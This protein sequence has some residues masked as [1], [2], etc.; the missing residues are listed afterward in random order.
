PHDRAREH[1]LA[2]AGFADD[3]E[4][5][6]PVERECHAVHGT[7][8]SPVRLEVRAGVADVEE[9]DVGRDGREAVGAVECLTLPAAEHHQIRASCTSKR[10]RM[11]SPRWFRDRTV[12]KIA[13][14]ASM[15]MCA[16]CDRL[17]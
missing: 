3:P 5:P 4:C 17:P 2:T 15:T 14:E 1:G 10:A 12:R 11:A 9:R 7:D 8:G 6:T 13:I 16:A